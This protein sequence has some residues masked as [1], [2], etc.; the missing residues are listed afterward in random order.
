MR[1]L[2][3]NFDGSYEEFIEKIKNKNGGIKMPVIEIHEN[4]LN[5]LLEYREVNKDFTFLFKT[6]TRRKIKSRFFGF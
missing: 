4:I 2:D 6:K 5:K 3:L 1:S